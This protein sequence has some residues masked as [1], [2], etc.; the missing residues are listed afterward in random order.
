MS[1][2]Q[3][4]I[5]QLISTRVRTVEVGGHEIVLEAPSLKEALRI[6]GEISSLGGDEEIKPIDLDDNLIVITAKALSLCLPDVNEELAGKILLNNS[7]DISNIMDAT[8]NLC[9]MP[10]FVKSLDERSRDNEDKEVESE[11]EGKEAEG[12]QGHTREEDAPFS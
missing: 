1:K 3:H 8:F 9:G 7:D 12:I 6:R 2:T 4:E 10:G 11:E 5:L